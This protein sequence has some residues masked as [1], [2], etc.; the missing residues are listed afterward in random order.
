MQRLDSAFRPFLF[1]LGLLGSVLLAACGSSA[2]ATPTVAPVTTP[3][4]TPVTPPTTTVMVPASTPT[5]TPVANAVKPAAAVGTP[6]AAIKARVAG[7]PSFSH[8]YVLVMENKEYGTVIGSRASPYVNSLIAQYGLATNYTG[9][10]HPSE[11][12]YFALFS[13]STQGATGDGIYNLSGQNLADQLEAAGK[14]WKVFAENVPTGCFAGAVAS[15]GEDGPGTYARKHEPAISFTD[16]SG[17]PTRCA[18]ITD[19]SHFDPAAANYELIV[20]N[21]CNDTH[22]CSVAV[23]DNFLKEFVPK[24]L[25]SPAWQ[26]GGVLFMTWDEGSS[27]LGNG[28]RVPL[29]VISKQVPAGFQSAGAYNH[30]SI[31]KTI[32]DAW[33]LDCLNLACRANN[34][35]AFFQK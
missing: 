22:D 30:Y 19:F 4:A 25:N 9:T 12:N 3:A 10:A 8:I 23:G 28:G 11:P 34:L 35:S 1:M 32:E 2:S 29:L 20:P 7:L 17:S 27:D 24:I 21:M 26:E 5:A 13:G 14:T 31:V 15:G 18:N 33:G 16:I 6:V